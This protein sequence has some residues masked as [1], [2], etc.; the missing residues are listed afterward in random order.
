MIRLR[1]VVAATALVAS[2]AILSATRATAQAPTQAQ[3]PVF[4]GDVTLVQVDVRVFDGDGRF[5]PTLTKED[6]E[7]FER[8]VRQPVE[9]FEL[10]GYRDPLLPHD[11]RPALARGRATDPH[12]WIFQF[13]RKHLSPGQFA[14]VR[15]AVELFIQERFVDGDIAGIVD[16]DKMVFDKISS[17]RAELLAAIRRIKP[18]GDQA[19]RESDKKFAENFGGDDDAS[20]AI[21]DS[22]AALGVAET[23]RA[24]LD[25]LDT[26]ANLFDGLAGIA[27]V[28]T[29]VLVS[30]GFGIAK[31]FE[32]TVRNV[33]RRGMRAGARVY[34]IDP[35]GLQRVGGPPDL[36]NTLSVDTGGMVIFHEN[37]FGRALDAIAADTGVYYLL[38]VRPL[39]RKFDG[40]YH[41]IDVRV[42]VPGVNVRARR[43]YLAVDPST[44]RS[45][46]GR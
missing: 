2:V 13:D 26:S 17:S 11:A 10:V 35:L 29:V 18:S 40:K 39:N 31:E 21:R 42:K 15:T 34:A 27:G 7:V 41:E 44:L 8:G 32:G 43:G 37:D 25:M 1:L 20:G 45:P 4:R 16:G 33:V 30:G 28:K 46:S 19:S 36:L 9:S 14:R 22:L 23:R 5:V 12:T 6:F 3:P 24:A 38:G